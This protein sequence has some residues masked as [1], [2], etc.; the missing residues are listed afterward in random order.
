MK[1]RISHLI[2]LLFFATAINTVVQA[3]NHQQDLSAKAAR[4]I[5]S[6]EEIEQ[7]KAEGVKFIPDISYRE[8]YEAC[9]L[10]LAMPT[11]AGTGP[12]PA[13]VFIHG[14]GWRNGDKRK[15]IFIMTALDFAAKGYVCISINYRL[16]SD[17]TTIATCVED[18]KCAVRWLRA[19]AE[20]YNVN[21]MR[22][23]A[24][25]HSAGAHLA[26][27][28]GI[29]GPSAGLEGDGPWQEYS[30]MVQ[31]VVGSAT[32][33]EIPERFRSNAMTKEELRNISPISHVSSDAPPFLL[34]HDVSDQTVPV[35][36]VDDFVTSMKQAGAKE[37]W[38]FRFDN[39]SGHGV[40]RNIKT[41]QPAMESFFM[42]TLMNK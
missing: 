42:Q 9:K 10:D 37:I 14:G 28:L 24:F 3:Q 31:S 7:Y 39:G 13:I 38:Y 16:L 1:Y 2:T 18:T 33:T 41:I 30:S 8:D 32:P 40:I 17:S 35:E 36:Q 20:E 19:H 21:P 6:L 27:M 26:A 34:I 29:C 23:G 12:R 5:F 22:I 11:E 4:K 15:G 25:G